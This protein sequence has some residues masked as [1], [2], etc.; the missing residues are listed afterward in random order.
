MRVIG[1]IPNLAGTPSQAQAGRELDKIR[2]Q[3]GPDAAQIEMN[4]D[5]LRS[6]FVEQ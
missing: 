3:L 4:S 1:G 2:V 6:D 5:G